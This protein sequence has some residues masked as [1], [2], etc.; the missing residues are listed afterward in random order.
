LLRAYGIPFVEQRRTTD[1]VAAAA[2]LGGPVA[3]KAVVPGLIHKGR[4]GGVHL[5]VVD[6]EAAA[7]ELADRFADLDCYVVQRMAAPGVGMR[8]GVLA[9]ERLG[10]VVACAAGGEAVQE[11]ADVQVRLAPL[12]RGEAAGMVRA[13]RTAAL[14]EREHADID[15]LVDV[16]VRVAALADAHPA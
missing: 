8:V 7:R 6:V 16:I 13:L 14:L 5:N 10:S 12:A 15:A 9:D 3:V 11:I 4:A 2:S 1:P